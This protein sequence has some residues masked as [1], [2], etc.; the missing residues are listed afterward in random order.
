MELAR[1]DLS[2]RVVQKLI[3]LT[4]S[5][6]IKLLFYCIISKYYVSTVSCFIYFYSLNY[7]EDFSFKTKFE[8]AEPLC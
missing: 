1:T 3:D 8:T 5:F 4:L 6:R 2:I 7:N